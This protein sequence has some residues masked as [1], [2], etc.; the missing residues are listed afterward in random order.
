MTAFLDIIAWRDLAGQF[1][2]S[3]IGAMQMTSAL[4]N[5]ARVVHRC[6]NELGISKSAVSRQFVKQSAQ[7]FAQLISRELSQI[8][9]VAV[10]TDGIIVARHHIIAAVGVDAQ[11][12]KTGL[13]H[14]FDQ[15]ISVDQYKRFAMLQVEWTLDTEV[16]SA[17]A[18]APS[19]ETKFLDHC[20]PKLSKAERLKRLAQYGVVR[21]T[22]YEEFAAG[23]KSVNVSNDGTVIYCR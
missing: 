20:A 4:R 12:K 23:D 3:P 2:V 19:A 22:G 1:P 11:G 7:A 21:E 6:A 13:A 18:P 8:D 5:Y 14:Q 9:F 16:P 17:T 15:Y 10:Y